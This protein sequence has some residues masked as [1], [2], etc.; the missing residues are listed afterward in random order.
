MPASLPA[1]VPIVAR[2]EGRAH[3]HSLIP[4]QSHGAGIVTH[5]SQVGNP[6]HRE[7]R[8]SRILRLLPREQAPLRARGPELRHS[9]R[10]MQ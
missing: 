1:G 10:R 9:T 3:T 5:T 7:P 6:R 4:H 2:A 8:V